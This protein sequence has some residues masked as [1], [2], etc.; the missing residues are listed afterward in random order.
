M[1]RLSNSLHK[2]WCS[3]ADTTSRFLHDSCIGCYEFHCQLLNRVAAAFMLLSSKELQHLAQSKSFV[4]RTVIA[5]LRRLLSPPTHCCF[6]GTLLT[7]SSKFS[8][9][10]PATLTDEDSINVFLKVNRGSE[11]NPNLQEISDT[12][13]ERSKQDTVPRI[14]FG[15]C[16]LLLRFRKTSDLFEFTCSRRS[17][18]F[19]MATTASQQVIPFPADLLTALVM[20]VNDLRT[21]V[22]QLREEL[23]Q[24]KIENKSLFG[25]TPDL[26]LRISSKAAG[27]ERGAFTA[28]PT[29]PIE[30]R[31]MIWET[32]L[33]VSQIIPVRQML[34]EKNQ[35]QSILI[36][37][38]P[39]S[40]IRQVNQEARARAFLLQTR[41]YSRGKSGVPGIFANPLS[42]TIWVTDCKSITGRVTSGIR[43]TYQ[44]KFPRI[45][46]P[47]SALFDMFS[48]LHGQQ[49]NTAKILGTLF[50]RG[51]TEVLCIVENHSNGTSESDRLHF[52]RPR[53]ATSTYI[54]Q[55]PDNGG[56]I[57]SRYHNCTWNVMEELLNKNVK[58]YIEQCKQSR[59]RTS[60]TTF[61]P[62][63]LMI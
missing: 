8:C 30:I 23:K 12:D 10:N 61:W 3:T 39:H 54:N 20:S 60:A 26:K 22:I 35:N 46:I 44:E 53:G 27:A 51:V 52:V 63:L 19:K 47:A 41:F 4:F 37:L 1:K 31:L 55:F 18:I 48:L 43:W 14:I 38:Q 24:E 13:V 11:I 45:A 50:R 42:D 7:C 28:F 17:T 62:Y 15:S 32:A 40:F 21:E 33:S 57:Q 25:N 5:F 6:R 36:P 29:L 56:S 58:A 59:G 34:I 9:Q 49:R 2:D 16:N